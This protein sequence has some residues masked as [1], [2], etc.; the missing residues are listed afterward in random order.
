MRSSATFACP[1]VR[2]RTCFAPSR[3]DRWCSAIPVHH[4]LRR[5]RA[6][7]QPDARGRARLSHQAVRHER[8]SGPARAD[9]RVRRSRRAIPCSACR[10]RCGS[11]SSS[12][13]GRRASNSNVLLTGETGVGKEVCARFLHTLR[14]KPNGPFMAVNCAAIPADLMES[15]LFGH[16]KGAFTGAHARHLGYAERAGQGVLFLDEVS[17][18]APKLQA[19]LLRRD[20]EPLVSPPGRRAGDPV[21]GATGLRDQC[22]S[23]CPRTRTAPS[24]RTST[25]GSTCYRAHVPPLRERV[26]DIEWLIDRF[27]AEFA[28]HDRER[29]RRRLGAGLRGRARASAGRATCASSGTGSNG[30]SPLLTAA[31]S[32]LGIC[33]PSASDRAVADDRFIALAG[34]GARRCRE[35][36]H[37]AGARNDGRRNTPGGQGARHLPHDAVG[38]NEALWPGRLRTREGDVRISEHRP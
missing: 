32:C 23:C 5:C 25:T 22:R 20:R 35:A 31:G 30:L 1:M 18:L 15:E 14:D 37:S 38:E 27:F 4:R 36:A 16:E 24:A 11:S 8:V 29:R 21:Q 17:E 33:F 10:R 6:G 13:G 26:E 2:A 9:P 12:C 3:A 34:H 7:R 28:A 19:K